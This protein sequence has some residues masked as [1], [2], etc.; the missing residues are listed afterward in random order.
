[1]QD[2]TV[3]IRLIAATNK[4]MR[5]AVREKAFRQ[6]LYFRLN[7]IQIEIPALRERPDDIMPMTNFFI[8]HYNRKFKRNILGVDPATEQILL[9]YDWP[10]NVR[11]LRTR[12]S[13][14]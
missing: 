4:N 11:E 6:D 9:Q 7:V 1:V 12:S 5:E 10:G 8:Q 14:R 3:D 13:G 2:I